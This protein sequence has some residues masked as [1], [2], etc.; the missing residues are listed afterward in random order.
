MPS[1]K[2]RVG[3]AGYGT[4]L[5]KLIFS[6]PWLAPERVP[7]VKKGIGVGRAGRGLRCKED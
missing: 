3:G 5:L 1:S 2:K 7:R 4:Q 6:V